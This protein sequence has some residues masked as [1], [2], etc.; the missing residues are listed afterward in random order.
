MQ[1]T[2]FVEILYVFQCNST[3]WMACDMSCGLYFVL[4][5]YVGD[6]VVEHAA[7]KYLSSRFICLKAHTAWFV[8]QCRSL[9]QTIDTIISK[10]SDQIFVS[11][12]HQFICIS[13]SDNEVTMYTG[14]V[15]FQ[16]RHIISPFKQAH[17]QLMETFIL[18]T[19][20][21]AAWFCS[22]VLMH[23]VG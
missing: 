1:A 17:C 18:A 20:L 15:A 7:I 12:H 10:W 4:L 2:I 5:K 14:D 21:W 13:Y 8:S 11:G 3:K 22:A 6:V 19:R 16:H 9:T 23:F